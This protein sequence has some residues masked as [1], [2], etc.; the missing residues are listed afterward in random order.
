[1]AKRNQAKPPRRRISRKSKEQKPEQ[2][3]DKG[4]KAKKVNKGK[5]NL[6]QRTLTFEETLEP[7]SS[8]FQFCLFLEKKIPN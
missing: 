4:S 3:T 2:V 5:K 7:V 8:Y 1:M 6:V